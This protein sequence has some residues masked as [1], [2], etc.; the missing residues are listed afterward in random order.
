[1]CN[2]RTQEQRGK[3]V[4]IRWHFSE[5]CIQISV[6]NINWSKGNKEGM[7]LNQTMSYLVEVEYQAIR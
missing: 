2:R 1:M 7:G 3:R 6:Y 5:I 4:C